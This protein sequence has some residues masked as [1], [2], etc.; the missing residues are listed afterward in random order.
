MTTMTNE[1]QPSTPL[2]ITVSPSRV[3]SQAEGHHWFPTML[4]RVQDGGLLLGYSIC[5]DEL[6]G[7]LAGGI[8]HAFL[9]SLDDGFNW[10]CQ[11]IVSGRLYG[12]AFPYGQLADGRLLGMLGGAAGLFLDEHGVPYTFEY[13]SDDGMRSWDGPRR[14][15]ITFP[16]SITLG[17]P[18]IAPGRTLAPFA[19]EGNLVTRHDGTLLRIADGKFAGDAYTR[20]GIMA[21]TDDGASWSYLAT[22]ADPT[23]EPRDFNESALLEVA[24]NDILCVMRTDRDGPNPLYQSR[25]HDGGHTWSVAQ[26]LGITGVRPQMV[27]LRNGVIACSY[28]RLNGVPTAGVQV[29]FS[30]DD[31][32]TW[33]GHTTV[34]DH[35]STGYTALLEI[36]P[37]ELLLVYD[38]LG[39]AWSH[40][41]CISSVT[42]SVAMDTLSR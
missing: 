40:V 10:V 38:A 21:S 39:Y 12:E 8:P 6:P 24:D 32:V 22:I 5:P 41:N 31:G 37:N 30:R 34:Y 36:Q 42:I 29:M 23:V 35:A 33:E 9:K 27:K 28:G 7:N 19:F 18:V 25:S 20:V 1:H 13:T 16:P 17:N 2:R 26:A 15:A 4:F 11:T 14:T 3:I